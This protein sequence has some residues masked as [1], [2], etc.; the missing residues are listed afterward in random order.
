[1]KLWQGLAAVFVL[2]AAL[3]A[4]AASAPAAALNALSALDS[5]RVAHGLPYGS[6]PRQRF[7]L[8]RPNDAAPAAGWPLVVFFYGGAWRRGERADYRFVGEALA[9]RGMVVMVADY[10]LHPLVRYPEFLR[11]SAIAL[12]HAFTQASA[13]GADSRRVFLMGHS[14]GAYIAAMLA[15]DSRWLAEQG[16]QPASL[17]GWI[18]VAGPYDFLPIRTLEVQPV[19]DHPNS[20]QDSQP[21]QHA[22]SAQ[23]R[24]LLVA[25]TQDERVDPQRNTVQ[26]ARR[27][28]QAGGTVQ[29]RLNAGVDHTS[30]LAS[31]AWPLRRLAPLLNDIQAFIGA[32][33]EAARPHGDR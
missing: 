22:S 25:P 8:Y 23:S 1:M 26:L 20:R 19:F 30:V 13:W 29:L 10:R 32:A 16:R 33:D 4:W 7:D 14:A 15:L 17:A 28:T 3:A 24:T 6:L 18:G 21:M 2:L 27:L 9:A 5:R 31:I 12:S 11:D